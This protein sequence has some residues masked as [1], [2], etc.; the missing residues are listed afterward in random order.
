MVRVLVQVQTT[1]TMRITVLLMRCDKVINDSD[2]DKRMNT[3]T[4]T[5][6]E[7]SEPR[8]PRPK[9]RRRTQSGGK[10]GTITTTKHD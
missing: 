1:W 3:D 7:A 4:R 6:E 5:T 9:P 8:P 10:T 2:N